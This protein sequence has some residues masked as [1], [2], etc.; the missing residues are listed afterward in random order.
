M[1]PGVD[2]RAVL[3]VSGA[4]SSRSKSHGDLSSCT[5]AALRT[6]SALSLSANRRPASVTSE[7]LTRPTR[8]A[9]RRRAWTTV[10]PVVSRVSGLAA[11]GDGFGEPCCGTL[12]TGEDPITA[13]DR[14][15]VRGMI[16]RRIGPRRDLISLRAAHREPSD[17]LPSPDNSPGGPYGRSQLGPQL[18][19]RRSRRGSVCGDSQR[20]AD[21]IPP[22]WPGRR[23]EGS[24][25]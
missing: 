8:P 2:D 4:W 17:S 10:L 3:R 18:D 24:I 9:P 23:L 13:R 6:V 7:A 25:A 1:A 20:S 12:P 11:V 16:M 21:G 5:G 15:A 22:S 19:W 14:R